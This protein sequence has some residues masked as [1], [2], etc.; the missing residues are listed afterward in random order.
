MLEDFAFLRDLHHPDLEGGCVLTIGKFDGVHRGHRAILSDV[1]AHADRLG[2]PAAVLTFEPHPKT[3]FRGETPDSFRLMPDDQRAS[4]LRDAGADLVLTAKFTPEFAALTPN[5]FVEALLIKTLHAKGVHVGYDFNF[6]KGRAG[7]TKTLQELT[8]PHGVTTHVHAPF[9][10]GGTPVSSTR[11]RECVERGDVTEAADLLG[12]PLTFIGTT[13]AGAGR[14]KGMGIPTLNLYPTG[15]LLPPHGVY[16][17]RLWHG[18]MSYQAIANLGCRPTFDDDD[19]V[20]LET[21]SLDPFE[22]EGRG[23]AIRVELLGFIRPE[24]RFESPEALRGQIGLDVAAAKA[25]HAA[26]AT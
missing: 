3:V 16:A 14:G 23:L 18:D 26:A 25:I 8:T 12:A 5:A 17:V 2:V 21:L 22:I 9:T 13:E 1:R 24:Q 19:R 11:I 6:G 20:S 10:A 4:T 7:D 15:R